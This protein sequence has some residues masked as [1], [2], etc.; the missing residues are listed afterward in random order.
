MT[1][2]SKPQKYKKYRLIA[3]VFRLVGIFFVVG[4]IGLFAG[5]YF[6]K[7]GGDFAA[8]FFN[9]SNY[10][11]IVLVFLPAVIFAAIASAYDEKA[12]DVYSDREIEERIAMYNEQN[13]PLKNQPPR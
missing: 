1:I 12:D 7:Y 2:P 11:L 3:S 10:V 4:G 6:G 5:L 9:L 8:F 13:D